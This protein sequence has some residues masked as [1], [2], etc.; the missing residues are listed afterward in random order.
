MAAAFDESSQSCA[1]TT[2]ELA[3]AAMQHRW[4]LRSP[5]SRRV[6]HDCLVCGRILFLLELPGLTLRCTGWAAGAASGWQPYQIPLLHLCLHIDGRIPRREERFM[7]INIRTGSAQA[8]PTLPLT[9]A[10]PS[11]LLLQVAQARL[12]SEGVKSLPRPP[13]CDLAAS[14]ARDSASHFQRHPSLDHSRSRCRADV[15][16]FKQSDQT[17]SAHLNDPKRLSMSGEPMEGTHR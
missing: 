1:R 5:R 15:Q 10:S 3:R 12:C 17:V 14:S 4:A 16:S 11:Q 8:L 6:Q 9:Q 13:P 2:V 7:R